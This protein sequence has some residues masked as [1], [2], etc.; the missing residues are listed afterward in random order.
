[1]TLFSIPLGLSSYQNATV[2][3]SAQRCVNMYASVAEAKSWSPV[4]LKSMAGVLSFGAAGTGVSRGAIE[5][6]GVL[7]VVNGTTLFSVSSLGVATSKGTVSGEKRVSMA[8]NGEKLCIVCPGLS[9]FNSYTYDST[10]DTLIQVSDVDYQNADSVCFKDGFYV[11]TQSFTGGQTN[12]FF[13]SALNDPLT[14]D[15]LDFGSAELAPD[16]IIGCH[17][18]HDELYILGEHTTEVFQNV[19][20]AGFPFQ[21]I[22][23]AS[24]EKGAHSK[25]SVIQ[26]EG[27]FY[28]IGGGKNEKSAIWRARG[29]GEPAKVSTDAIDQELQKFTAAETAE[30]FSFTYSLDGSA[31]VGFT[32]RSINIASRTFVFN[33]T[34]S[35]NAGTRVWAEQQSGVFDNA[36]RAQSVTNVY[37][38][39]VIS[40]NVDGRLGH[41]DT[42]TYTE[43][44]ETFIREKITPPFAGDSSS[45][46]LHKIELSI[47]AGRGQISGQGLDPQ[48]EMDF[49]DDGARTWSN[50]TTRAMGKIGEYNKRVEWRRQGR[51]P[52]QRVFRF[53]V[54]DPVSVSF[55]KLEV[56]GTRGR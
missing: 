25:Y 53:R 10:A 49:S 28:F 41:L 14:F 39:L 27:S 9:G 38:K 21:R 17:V 34:A 36:W 26:W 16:G 8:H 7:Y 3:F 31:F 15:G 1:M 56:D 55:V 51:I 18:S 4:M 40:D 45:L 54:S 29:T 11:F 5:M 32:I 19:G 52:A 37:D 44:G 2:P 50:K 42:G 47:D 12:K 23:G 35:Q 22:P 48:V 43:Y 6:N 24:F 33:V 13:N 30:A 46:F 20:G